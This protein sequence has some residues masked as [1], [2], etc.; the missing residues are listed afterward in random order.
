MDLTLYPDRYLSGMISEAVVYILK[1]FVL[2]H[3]DGCFDVPGETSE[4]FH[5]QNGHF[6][7]VYLV[8]CTRSCVDLA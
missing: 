7:L 6:Y 4:M 1:V 8:S 2:R 5:F 3:D